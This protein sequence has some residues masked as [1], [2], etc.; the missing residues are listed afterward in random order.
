MCWN[1]KPFRTPKGPA[2]RNSLMAWFTKGPRPPSRIRSTCN[3][4]KGCPFLKCQGCWWERLP[5]SVNL[6]WKNLCLC[7]KIRGSRQAIHIAIHD[8]FLQPV[9][10]LIELV[11]SSFQLLLKWN[12]VPEFFR[13]NYLLKNPQELDLPDQYYTTLYN[14]YIHR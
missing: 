14:L 12:E 13:H 1:S 3:F 5:F 4:R 11:R 9:A 6:H 2:P 10:E 7:Q 8:N